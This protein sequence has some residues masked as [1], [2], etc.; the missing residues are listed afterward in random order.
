M[1]VLAWCPNVGEGRRGRAQQ[2]RVILHWRSCKF[3]LN[4]IVRGGG[5]SGCADWAS[6]VR[7]RCATSLLTVASFSAVCSWT[8]FG[9][10]ALM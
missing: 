1:I 8:S 7:L 6:S 5:I 4:R 9:Q 10:C 2:Q 3:A